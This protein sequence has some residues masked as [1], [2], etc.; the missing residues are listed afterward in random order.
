[1]SISQYETMPCIIRGV[2]GLGH[3]KFLSLG[4]RGFRDASGGVQGLGFRMLGR[5]YLEAP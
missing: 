5:G 2:V 4:F 1:M 3:S